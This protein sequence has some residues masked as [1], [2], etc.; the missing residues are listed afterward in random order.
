MII[1]IRIIKLSPAAQG[2]CRDQRKAVADLSYHIH[3]IDKNFRELISKNL[4]IY[5]SGSPC[6]LLG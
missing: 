3:E 2:S 4:K 1:T 6:P 5:L